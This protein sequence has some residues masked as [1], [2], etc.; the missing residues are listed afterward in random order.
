MI[1]GVGGGF[2]HPAYP[3]CIKEEGVKGKH[4]GKE[5]GLEE[6]KGEIRGIFRK[7]FIGLTFFSVKGGGLAPVWVQAAALSPKPFSLGPENVL[8]IN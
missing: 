7:L 8:T 1:A 2:V 3:P 4:K 6:G 5:N